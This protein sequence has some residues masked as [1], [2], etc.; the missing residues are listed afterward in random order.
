M[1]INLDL[2]A[3]VSNFNASNKTYLAFDVAAEFT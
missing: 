1:F 3:T 2:G